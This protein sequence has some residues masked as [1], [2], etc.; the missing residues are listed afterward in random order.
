MATALRRD[1]TPYV[2]MQNSAAATSKY[3]HKGTIVGFSP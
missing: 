2:P 3:I 1:N